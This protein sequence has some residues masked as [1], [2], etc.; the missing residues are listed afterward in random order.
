MAS[1]SNVT[2]LVTHDALNL[3]E[4]VEHILKFL[5]MKELHRMA[6]YVAHVWGFTD[7]PLASKSASCVSRSQVA[8]SYYQD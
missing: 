7:T 2:A 1:V 6:R 8:A 4:I 5:P 3:D